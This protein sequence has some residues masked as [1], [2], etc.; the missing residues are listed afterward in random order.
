MS[1]L[2]II[3]FSF[4]LGQLSTVLVVDPVDVGTRTLRGGGGSPTGLQDI[5]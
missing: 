3:S 2:R 1:P 4:T 5:V